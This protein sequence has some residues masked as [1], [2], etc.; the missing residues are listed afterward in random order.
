[1][2]YYL[3]LLLT[4]LLIYL[5]LYQYLINSLNFIYFFMLFLSF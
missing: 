2:E 3:W 5:D 1:M 4:L